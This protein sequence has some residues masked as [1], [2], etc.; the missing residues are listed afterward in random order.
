MY[1][2]YT[3]FVGIKTLHTEAHFEQAKNA[4]KTMVITGF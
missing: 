2:L 1:K 3:G 4:D